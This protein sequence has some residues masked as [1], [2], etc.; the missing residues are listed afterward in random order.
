MNRVCIQP[1]TAHALEYID[2][3]LQA[4]GYDIKKRK[5][6]FLPKQRLWQV[7]LNDIFCVL[8]PCA[9][10]KLEQKQKL[11]VVQSSPEGQI[12]YPIFSEGGKN[13]PKAQNIGIN[14]IQSLVDYGLA[15]RFTSIILISNTVTTPASKAI[16]TSQIKISHFSYAETV[17]SNLVD[18]CLQP[19]NFRKLS[20]S[21]KSE[22]IRLNPNYT[23]ELGKYSTSEP[24]VKFFGFEDNDLISFSEY[25]LEGGIV[26]RYAIVASKFN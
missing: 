13:S 5:R 26:T 20:D 2:V 15:Q 9:S 1:P 7:F 10:T 21:E 16:Q 17:V 24:L 18:H 22:F 4:R 14:F 3:M 23:K 12:K 6:F 11:Q 19:A 25:E 8:T